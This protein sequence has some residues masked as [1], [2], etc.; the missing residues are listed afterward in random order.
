MFS[1]VRDASKIALVHLCARLIFGGYRLLDTQF[2]TDHLR[3]FG[4]I[5]IERGD[6][7][8]LLAPALEAEGQFDRLPPSTTGSEAL[9]IIASAAR[10]D[11]G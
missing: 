10:G 6:F 7:H 1:A 2:V 4:T 3:Q 5:E 11:G 9:A 8:K